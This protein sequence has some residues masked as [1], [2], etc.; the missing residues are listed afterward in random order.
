MKVEESVEMWRER[1]R[2]LVESGMPVNAWCEENHV[3]RSIL[4]R[5]LRRFRD[6]EPEVL[7]GFELAHAGDGR[8][9]WYEAV[10]KAAA[11]T[12]GARPRPAPPA[13]VPCFVEVDL[14][15]AWAGGVV[16]DL[17][18]MTATVGPGADEVALAALLRA[19]A[20]L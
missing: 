5:W 19:A 15:P 9:N 8:R 12:P 10:R 4:F 6:E 1:A 11:G 20:S 2:A 7:G 14:A 13:P 18:S 17:R 16:V 3:K